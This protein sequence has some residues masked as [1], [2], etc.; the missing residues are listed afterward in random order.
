MDSGSS[1]HQQAVK[2]HPDQREGKLVLLSLLS[3]LGHNTRLCSAI[4]NDG[5]CLLCQSRNNPDGFAHGEFIPKPYPSRAADQ[6]D[7]RVGVRDF[8]LCLALPGFPYLP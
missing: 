5:L 7:D 3:D 6:N 2:H 8:K 4:D 1:L